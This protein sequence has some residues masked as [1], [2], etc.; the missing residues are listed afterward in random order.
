MKFGLLA[1]GYKGLKV[2]EKLNHTP[3]FVASY[4]NKEKYMFEKIKQLCQ[5]KKIP[6]YHRDDFKHDIDIEKIFTVGWQF[7][8]K[9]NLEKYIVLHDSYLPERRGFC[10]TVSALCDGCEHLGAS[11]FRPIEGNGPDYGV[12]VGREKVNIVH[13]MKID[14]AFDIV[15]D[16]YVSLIDKLLTEKENAVEVD[17]K[18]STF[19]IWQDKNDF[20][21]NW[22]DTAENIHRKICASGY[23]YDGATTMYDGKLIHIKKST[24]CEPLNILNQQS[25]CGK[26]WTVKNGVAT[27]ICGSGLLDVVSDDIEFTLLRKRF[28]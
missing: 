24:V 2:L 22:S 7:L 9:E 3:V 14:V 10:P 26:F 20:R 8:V 15:S 27:V 5:V 23:P 13:P 11:A 25:N 19:S 1:T 12:V 16:L 17:Y 21:I 18:Q 28:L 4:D 6:F